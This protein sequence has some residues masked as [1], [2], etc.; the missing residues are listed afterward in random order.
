VRIELLVVA[1]QTLKTTLFMP[2]VNALVGG[3]GAGT[4][5][6]AVLSG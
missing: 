2:V 5:L 3:L 1:S 6:L 4:K